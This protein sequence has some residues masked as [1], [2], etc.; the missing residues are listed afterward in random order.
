MSARID[1]EREFAAA[2]RRVRQNIE[3]NALIA[4]ARI[5]GVSPEEYTARQ[6][7]E[8]AEAEQRARNRAAEQLGAALR[9]MYDSIAAAAESI[10]R[11]WNSAGRMR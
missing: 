11:G 7:V 4:M 10:A 3:R 2:N 9:A 6:A 5:A 1:V 8:R